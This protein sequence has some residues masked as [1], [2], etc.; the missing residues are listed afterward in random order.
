MNE[1]KIQK[2]VEALREELIAFAEKH[3][4]SKMHLLQAFHD[5]ADQTGAGARESLFLLKDSLS[6][7]AERMV[8]KAN[9]ANTIPDM[10]LDS[11]YDFLKETK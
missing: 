4:L 7:T 3:D 2:E 5:I 6:S 8:F 10:F 11:F 9:S 1:M